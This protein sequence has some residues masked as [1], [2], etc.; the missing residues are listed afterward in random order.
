MTDKIQ[1]LLQKEAS[2]TLNKIKDV[3]KAIVT[4]DSAKKALRYYSK[5]A[6]KF[7]LVQLFAAIILY[8]LGFVYKCLQCGAV[9]T[10]SLFIITLATTAYSLFQEVEKKCKGKSRKDLIVDILK[11]SA[12]SAGSFTVGYVV[13]PFILFTGFSK[14][15]LIISAG[16]VLVP[17]ILG[18]IVLAITN[19]FFIFP[20]AIKKIC[21]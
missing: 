8:F 6:G 3:T 2:D 18:T 7:G 16:K 5:I 14:I 19:K 11:F 1:D 4:P 12:M 9:R 20:M 13:L 10:S 17:A 15:I 21:K